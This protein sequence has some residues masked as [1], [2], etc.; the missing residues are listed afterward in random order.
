MGK[1]SLSI[2][3]FGYRHDT[4]SQDAILEIVEYARNAD[5]AGF[6]RI[7]LGEHHSQMNKSCWSSP[8]MMIP[9]LLGST[10]RINVG[11]GGTLI[12]Y[13]SP[14]EKAT[15]YKFLANLYPGRVDLGF[16]NGSTNITVA[17]ALFNRRIRKYPDN[18]LSNI[19]WIAEAYMNEELLQGQGVLIPPYGGD[20]PDLYLLSSSGFKNLDMAIKC[21]LNY[22]K[23]MF[24]STLNIDFEKDNIERFRD[25]FYK[26]NGVL[27][28]I[29]MCFM[30]IC[31][32]NDAKAIKSAK[33][34]MKAHIGGPLY[35]EIVGGP[36]KFFDQL[37]EYSLKFGVD[38]F[39]LFDCSLS[40]EEKIEAV[41]LL[42]DKF[43]L[44]TC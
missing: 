43:K 40:N 10:D 9:I 38:E 27:P 25:N 18:F 22:S 33:E 14:Y 11:T 20:V 15:N 36:S 31:N 39:L 42:S 41:H 29:N 5:Q 6:S 4:Y 1:I 2:L 44:I 37:N 3:E 17:K 7:W 28:K 12:N 21:K 24:H 19:K 26:A 30:G 23:S 13:Y 8:E 16:A 34:Y 35:N 32:A